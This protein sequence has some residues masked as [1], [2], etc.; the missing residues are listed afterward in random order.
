MWPDNKNDT[1]RRVEVE[2]MIANTIRILNE[3]VNSLN[4][5][6]TELYNTTDI[7]T[8]A[9]L[10]NFINIQ[11]ALLTASIANITDQ[12]E[13]IEGFNHNCL[14][15]TQE[16]L[17]K[18]KKYYIKYKDENI[19]LKKQIEELRN[20]I[21]NKNNNNNNE[22]ILNKIYTN[23]NTLMQQY[24]L[25]QGKVDIKL[26]QI[27]NNVNSFINDLQDS[28]NN[29]ALNK[30]IRSD[31]FKQRDMKDDKNPHYRQ[32]VNNDQLITDYINGI[33]PVELAA[34]Y[35][36]TWPGIVYRLKKAG[37]YKNKKENE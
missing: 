16:A 35:N 9:E 17:E 27:D 37:V 29:I 33:G 3:T 20:Q 26:D 10:N 23:I 19:Q 4:N 14:N 13:W 24:I 25:K 15:S 18:Y 5:M 32:D 8:Y 21:N 36:M 7:K 30:F 2:Y 28:I 34:K 22:D 1:R 12:I 6:Y 31:E 11:G